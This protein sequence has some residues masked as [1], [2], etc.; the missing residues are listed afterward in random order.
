MQGIA[1]SLL[2][3]NGQTYWKDCA[4][5]DI[6]YEY[7]GFAKALGQI[8]TYASSWGGELGKGDILRWNIGSTSLTSGNTCR[9]Q[10]HSEKFKDADDVGGYFCS[11]AA[12]FHTNTWLYVGNS[13][14]IPE[15]NK[16]DSKDYNFVC[17]GSA[18]F[19]GNTTIA[20]TMRFYP[21]SSIQFYPSTIQYGWDSKEYVFT[22]STTF[23]GLMS[24]IDNLEAENSALK[25]RVK[26]LEE[27]VAYLK[28]LVK[29]F[30]L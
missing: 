5:Y 13:D 2:Q 1:D 24:R 18:T 25:N 15:C 19:R 4:N 21:N 11:G 6:L 28:Q 29:H 22:K 26:S 7:L 8:S 14:E 12:G 3:R 20:S 27:D 9:I 30:T 23:D 17:M 10:V 16:I